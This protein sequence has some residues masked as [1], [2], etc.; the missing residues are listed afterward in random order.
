MDAVAVASGGRCASPS[1]EGLPAAS[2]VYFQCISILF[3][4]CA[5]ATAGGV[6]FRTFH[7]K[8]LADTFVSNLSHPRLGGVGAATSGNAT[9][10]ALM[11]AA[12]CFIPTVPLAKHERGGGCR[13]DRLQDGHP[14]P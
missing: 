4:Y 7:F 2:G 5:G 11:M 10:V 9:S 6:S 1:G 3:G 8:T 13:C 14:P 12:I